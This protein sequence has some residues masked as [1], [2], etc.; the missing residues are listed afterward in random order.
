MYKELIKDCVRGSRGDYAAA[1]VGNAVAFVWHFISYSHTVWMKSIDRGV[2]EGDNGNALWRA[3]Q[4]GCRHLVLMVLLL[5]T[6]ATP[7]NPSRQVG[8]I[9]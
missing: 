2:V 3:G 4:R 5:L 9:V 6:G 8:R 1:C 7:R